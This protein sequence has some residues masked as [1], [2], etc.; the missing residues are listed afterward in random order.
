[1]P[2][3]SSVGH[4]KGG[5]LL[6][7]LLA[8]YLYLITHHLIDDFKMGKHVYMSLFSSSP[9]CRFLMLLYLFGGSFVLNGVNKG[10][11]RTVELTRGG[12]G[13]STRFQNA[14]CSLCW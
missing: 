9:S 10:S 1:M 14:M 8:T 5:F 11:M 2:E 13:I 3:S 7:I 4:K 6:C 12:G